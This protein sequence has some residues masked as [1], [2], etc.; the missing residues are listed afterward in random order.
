M[1]CMTTQVQINLPVSAPFPF[2]ILDII[3]V[4]QIHPC[5]KNFEHSITTAT[6]YT[7]CG[8]TGRDMAQFAVSMPSYHY[9]KKRFKAGLLHCAI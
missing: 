3:S 9:E 4:G 1:W 2:K 5:S 8:P 7:D 6:D